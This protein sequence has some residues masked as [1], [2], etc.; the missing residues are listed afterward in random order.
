MD[1]SSAPSK[2]HATFGEGDENSPNHL[3]VTRKL[4]IGLPVD[5]EICDA[6]LTIKGSKDEFLRITVD[7]GNN[8]PGFLPGDYLKTLDVGSQSAT[9]KLHLPKR[10]RSRVIIEVPSAVPSL[11]L[12]LVRGNLSFETERIRG[13]RKINVVFGHVE[14][15]TNTDAY[16]I[17]N[18]NV[19]MGR[20]HDHRPGGEQAL[21]MVSKSFAG[22][23]RGSIDLNVVRGSVD[24]R[25]WD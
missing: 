8:A 18:M 12:N 3:R 13:D 23:G 17:L 2:I 7:V 16:S 22:V 15:L 4:S 6:D 21:G 11:K 5:L 14:M 20:F 10:P 9:V 24:V 19:L 1:C 25:A